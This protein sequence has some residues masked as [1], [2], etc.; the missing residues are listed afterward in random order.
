MRGK[1]QGRRLWKHLQ[2][3]MGHEKAGEGW[4]EALRNVMKGSR[5]SANVLGRCSGR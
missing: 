5:Y 2:E 4:L 3:S 1:V